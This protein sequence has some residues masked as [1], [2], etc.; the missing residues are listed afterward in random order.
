M[1]IA[2]LADIHGNILALDAV[3]DDLRQRGGADLVVNLGD[4]VSGP[5]WP[6]ETMERLEALDLPTVRGNHDRRVARDPLD[7][8]MWPSDR[9]AYDRLKPAQ[10]EALFAIPLTLEIAPGVTA[11]H[12]R[13]DH[14]EKYLTDTMADG[15]LVRAPLAAIKRRLAALDPACRIVLCGH[16]HRSELIRIPDGPVVFNPGS[17]GCPA[18]DDPTPPAHVS[19]QGSPHARYGIIELGEPGRPDRFEAIAVD[20]DHE[21]A[22]RQ[23]EQAG[24]PEWA[25]ALRTGFISG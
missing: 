8:A 14:D 2:V 5:L 17:I 4:C 20:Y 19:E 15:R 24:R 21:A 13:P 3:L 16:S 25:H 1:R 6:R 12:A 23:A 9:Y 10:R 7:D 11:F 18:Y 22:A